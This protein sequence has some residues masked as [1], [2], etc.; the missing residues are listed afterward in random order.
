MTGRNGVVADRNA[1]VAAYLAD[2]SLS[3]DALADRFQ[4]SQRAAKYA[5]QTALRHVRNQGRRRRSRPVPPPP[6]LTHEKIIPVYPLM[7]VLVDMQKRID[8][9]EDRVRSLECALGFDAEAALCER[10]NLSPQPARVLACLA[11]GRRC[12]REQLIEAAYNRSVADGQSNIMRVVIRILRQRLEPL[13]V[14]I[15]TKYTFG[16]KIEA[17]L[18]IVRKA[19]QP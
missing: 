16:Y 5:L 19:M 15:S 8:D 1:I 17:G 13:G 3:V 6:T 18:D 10:F 14:K 11:Q 9:L 4:C 12:T 7:D 2:R